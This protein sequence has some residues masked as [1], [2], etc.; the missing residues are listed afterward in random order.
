MPKQDTLV[1]AKCSCCSVK[2]EKQ[3]SA[4]EIEK[5]EIEGE[6]LLMDRMTG[7]YCLSGLCLK[8]NSE[9]PDSGLESWQIKCDFCGEEFL[10]ESLREVEVI[11]NK[12]NN[13]GEGKMRFICPFCMYDRAVETEYGE[14]IIPAYVR[15]HYF[16]QDLK[17]GELVEDFKKE[18][19]QK[20]FMDHRSALFANWKP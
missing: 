17:W 9:T 20:Q 6:E 13:I 18:S 19:A 3:I 2:I 12:S 15:L 14:F 16:P 1:D 7:V 11:N 4:K 5:R 8:C 10:F